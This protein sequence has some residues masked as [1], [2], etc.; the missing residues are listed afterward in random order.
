MLCFNK[1]TGVL[2]IDRCGESYYASPD[3][4]SSESTIEASGVRSSVRKASI[5]VCVLDFQPFD[6]FYA[7]A[8]PT[9]D[10]FV[11]VLRDRVFTGVFCFVSFLVP[12]LSTFTLSVCAK[13]SFVRTVLLG[14]VYDAT[15]AVS[16]FAFGSILQPIEHLIFSSLASSSSA[17]S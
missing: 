11:Q 13:S 14:S 1:F 16:A 2:R 9:D 12:S 5:G 8:C 10:S 17:R 7:Q 4:K 15:L 6:C 3:D